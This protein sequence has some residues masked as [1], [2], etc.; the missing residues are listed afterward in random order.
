MRNGERE[1]QKVCDAAVKVIY[2]TSWGQAHVSIQNYWVQKAWEEMVRENQNHGFKNLKTS[3]IKA[4]QSFVNH[5]LGN[6][7]RKSVST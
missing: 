3:F 6:S 7:R 1:W 2:K 4:T 5:E